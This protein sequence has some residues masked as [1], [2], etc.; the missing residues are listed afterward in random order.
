MKIIRD[1]DKQFGEGVRYCMRAI[2]NKIDRL[3][4]EGCW[5]YALGLR[6]LRDDIRRDFS[7]ADQKR[8]IVKWAK[9]TKPAAKRKKVSKR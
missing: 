4:A 2:D 7:A 1:I 3:Q 5:D 6:S 9:K 8:R